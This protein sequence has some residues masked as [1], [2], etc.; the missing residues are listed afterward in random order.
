MPDVKGLISIIV[1]VYNVEGYIE[2]CAESIMAQTYKN[3]E[4]ILV[5]DGS[6][7]SSGE[8]C[9][10]Y[11]SMDDRIKV[12]HQANAG[13]S[14]ARNN[15]LDIATG[16]YIG[17]VDSD[18]FI[19]PDMY[20][21]LYEKAVESGSDIVE[22]NLHHTFKKY[23]DTEV[24]VKYVNKKYLL[25]MGRS[26][27]WNKIYRQELIRKAGARFPP[28]LYYEDLEFF[29]MLIPYVDKYEYVDIVAYHYVQRAVSINNYSTER[30][31]HVFHILNNINTFYEKNGI[32]DEY[33]DAL[34][35]FWA[36]ILLCSS[37]SR[38]CNIPN[39]SARNE[40]LRENL[41]TL[42]KRY[43]QWRKNPILKKQKSLRAIY[44]KTIN[45]ATY[46]IYSCIF[47]VLYAIK[48]RFSPKKY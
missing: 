26:V 23:E 27:V 1:P 20:K 38:I 19:D 17:F 10:R 39:I 44:M 18:D 21:T 13:L 22:C 2:K 43:P 15:A 4:I 11:A 47:P 7:D 35:F 9:D 46:K 42:I 37:F 33:H 25:C 5:N 28:G 16:E 3:L 24:G 41:S 32:Y 31:K 30:T 45:P 12:I 8:L 48:R 14:C 34:E 29:A 6:T 36:R 40:V